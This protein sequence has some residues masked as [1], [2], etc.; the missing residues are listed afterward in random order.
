MNNTTERKF[1]KK[2]LIIILTT[3]IPLL[4]LLVLIPSLITFM[5]RGGNLT[6]KKVSMLNEITSGDLQHIAHRGLF[7]P[8][9][10]NRAENTLPS[11]EFAV[12]KHTSFEL[13]V[14]FTKDNKLAVIHDDTLVLHA[15]DKNIVKDDREQKIINTKIKDLTLDEINQ[16]T[17]KYGLY[18]TPNKVPT[19]D[20]VLTQTDNLLTHIDYRNF[21]T[22]ILVEIKAGGSD[23]KEY[24]ANLCKATYETLKNFKNE[25][26][27]VLYAIQSFHPYVL[28]WFAKNAP[29][30]LRGFLSKNFSAHHL[31][32]E[33]KGVSGYLLGNLYT[34]FLAR[35]DFI[36]YE[37]KEGIE[38]S[39]GLKQYRKLYNPYVF[40]WTIRDKAL[41]NK[42]ANKYDAFIFDSI[43]D[44]LVEN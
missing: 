33:P 9:H 24:I 40:C 13:D 15:I 37:Y 2:Y 12:K 19:L 42:L 5:H 8:K 36:A 10:A 32:G 38:E 7:H 31:Q 44:F 27:R 28:N 30:V 35:P 21:K 6:A 18:N 39:L 41:M 23:S 26:T 11:F 4:L 1:L 14:H 17:Q 34:N 3:T 43:A 16:V 25:S 20:E 29:E 22:F